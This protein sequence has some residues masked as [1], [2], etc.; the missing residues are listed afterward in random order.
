MPVNLSATTVA[1]TQSTPGAVNL[2]WDASSDNVGVSGYAIYRDGAEVG[3]GGNPDDLRRP[4]SPTGDDVQLPGASDGRVRQPVRAQHPALS[5]TTP[6]IGALFSDGFE[7]GDLSN[8][9]TV[10][11]LQTE[12]SDTYGGSYAAEGTAADTRWSHTP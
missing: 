1:Q 11:G 10:N 3:H 8:W 4:D 12:S 7:S 2:S 9:T 6:P 5:V